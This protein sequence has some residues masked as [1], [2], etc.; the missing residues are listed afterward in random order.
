M[1]VHRRTSNTLNRSKENLLIPQM[2]KWAKRKKIH[3]CMTYEPWKQPIN[4]ELPKVNEGVTCKIQSLVKAPPK[5]YLS[6]ENKAVCDIFRSTSKILQQQ[7]MLHLHHHFFS[8]C[9]IEEELFNNYTKPSL[10]KVFFSPNNLKEMKV[11]SA[12]TGT[13]RASPTALESVCI[14]KVPRSLK[15]TQLANVLTL[16]DNMHV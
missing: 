5:N 4:V 13:T 3:S 16:Q 6:F 9:T 1:H 11:F 2:V 12:C 15:E 7:K 14:T 10:E 8:T